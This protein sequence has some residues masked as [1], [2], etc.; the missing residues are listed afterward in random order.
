MTDIT[1]NITI[2][3]GGITSLM[4]GLHGV[5]TEL[6]LFAA[7]AGALAIV[8]AV[9]RGTL[10]SSDEANVATIKRITRVLLIC[11]FLGLATAIVSAIWGAVGGTGSLSGVFGQVS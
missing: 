11:S 10:F 8:L 1:T 3:Q 5:T 9:C 2:N 4:S 7:A 6:V